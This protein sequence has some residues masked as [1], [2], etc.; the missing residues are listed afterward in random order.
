MGM[1]LR[2]KRAVFQVA[3]LLSFSALAAEEAPLRFGDPETMIDVGTPTAVPRAAEPERAEKPAPEADLAGKIRAIIATVPSGSDYP[4]QLSEI[5]DLG[6]PAVPPLVSLFEDASASWQAR[7]IAGIALGRLGTKAAREALVKGLA[8]SLFLIR[9]ASI[10]ALTSLGHSGVAALLRPALADRA[11]VVRC[12]AVDSL[13]QLRD[14]D[15]I[16]DLV[17]ELGASRNFY[18]GRS[19]WIRGRIVD[20]LGGIGDKKAVPALLAILREGELELRLRACGAL[21]KISPDAALTGPDAQ[22]EKCVEHW[23][24]W[25]ETHPLH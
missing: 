18:R 14:G 10:Q 4:D 2:G 17:K 13:E 12:K 6:A 8:D 5:V 21:T 19:L 20:A 16:P 7:W 11:M 24:K 3:L 9:M 22:S 23:S 1:D 15:S 25:G